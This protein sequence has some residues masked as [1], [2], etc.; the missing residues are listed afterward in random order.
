MQAPEVKAAQVAFN[1]QVAGAVETDKNGFPWDARIHS[2]NHAKVADGTWRKRRGIDDATVAQVEGELRAVMGAPAAQPQVQAP[3]APQ[4]V[5]LPPA[6]PLAIPDALKRPQVPAPEAPAA[7]PVQ[8]PAADPMAGFVQLVSRTSAAIG[9][10]KIKQD[11]VMAICQQHGVPSL[12]MLSNRLD[13]LPIIAEAIDA[14]I[15]LAG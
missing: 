1:Q 5:P 15:Q 8:A 4:A 10:G 12:P 9:N 11:Q 14:L 2:S 3:P 7:P 13:L 6:D